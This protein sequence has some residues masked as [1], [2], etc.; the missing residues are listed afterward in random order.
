MFLNSLNSK[1]K[2]NFMK[3]AVA[4]IKADGVVDISEKEILDV[5]AN[6]MR[7]KS[8]DLEIL[9]NIDDIIKEFA[10]ESTSQT[11]RVI[12]VELL[13]LAYADGEYV[14][15]ERNIIQKLAEAFELDKDFIEK[16]IGLEDA[17]TSVYKTLINLVTKGE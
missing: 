16:V 7:I 14:V 10:T 11:K 12:F 15:E 3:L 1:E 9:T 6:E 2:D 5:Y 8:Y 13:A 17:Y 4:L